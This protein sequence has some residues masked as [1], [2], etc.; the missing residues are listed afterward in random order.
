M[1]TPTTENTFTNTTENAARQIPRRSPF[2]KNVNY[3]FIQQQQQIQQQLQQS[4]TQNYTENVAPIFQ[5]IRMQ[6]VHTNFINPASKNTENTEGRRI[7]CPPPPG[8]T[9]RPLLPISRK[10]PHNTNNTTENAA[11]NSQEVDYSSQQSQV[12]DT[13]SVISYEVEESAQSITRSPANLNNLG[14]SQDSDPF[15][16]GLIDDVADN[17]HQQKTS[18]AQEDNDEPLISDAQKTAIIASF[19]A[20]HLEEGIQKDT[21]DLLNNDI[22]AEIS[23]EN[24]EDEQLNQ[25]IHHIS[26]DTARRTCELN[27][28]QKLK[29][30]KKCMHRNFMKSIP[31]ITSC[32]MMNKFPLS[33]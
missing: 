26:Q 6:R 29:Q 14:E 27:K 23:K 24:E 2:D 9:E 21:N 25:A 8:Y 17:N 13:G 5:P 18:F 12:T 3:E 31:N 30:G 32:L 20:E 1:S 10:A 16:Q 7:S 28:P 19:E 11:Q 4:N 33:I 15:L 22:P